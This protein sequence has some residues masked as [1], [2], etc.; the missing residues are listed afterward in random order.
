MP[1]YN[2]TWNPSTPSYDVS[3]SAPSPDDYSIGTYGEFGGSG[4]STV[5]P[6]ESMGTGNE[7]SGMTST[8]GSAWTPTS[9][10]DEL[11]GAMGGLTQ[12]A[13][14]SNL[15]PEQQWILWNYGEF[16]GPGMPEWT[17]GGDSGGGQGG[18]TGGYGG[19]W[20]Y[21]GG[22]GGGGGG[23]GGSRMQFPG[24]E[25]AGGMRGRWGQSGLHRR[26]IDRMRGMNRGGIVSLC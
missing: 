14:L 19:G 17:G 22:S 13:G 9:S 25:G 7:W 20:G 18:G 6:Y 15:T 16:G 12:D 26:Y 21:G 3:Y 23:S 8:T 2:E 11:I 5:D 1:G 4:I 24:A 10:M